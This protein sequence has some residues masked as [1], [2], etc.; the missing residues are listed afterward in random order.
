MDERRCS[1]LRLAS[2]IP[3]ACGAACGTGGV[4]A[5][6]LVVHAVARPTTVSAR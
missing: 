5:A 4:T 3:N 2:A 1:W 6:G